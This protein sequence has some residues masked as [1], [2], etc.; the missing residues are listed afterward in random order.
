M[1]SFL[2]RSSF[3]HKK[4]RSQSRP[5]LKSLLRFRP[6]I[7]RLEDRTLPSV[8]LGV[9][10]AGING[11]NS[12]CGCLPPDGAEAIGP[13]N[14]IEGVNLAVET[15]DRSGNL[16]SG[17]TALRTFFSGHGFTVNSLS[18]P[19]I[20]FDESVVNSS[21]LNGRFIVIILDFTSGSAPDK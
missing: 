5:C 13:L 2:T 10:V 12:S 1:K 4:G 8:T 3:G 14:A 7:D 19:V 18:D 17:P 21:G 11:A 15:T 9:H 20:Y 16:I 6:Q